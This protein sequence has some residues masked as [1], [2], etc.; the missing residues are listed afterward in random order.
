MADP[1]AI[2]TFARTFG[3]RRIDLLISNAALQIKANPEY[4][5]LLVSQDDV[6]RELCRQRAENPALVRRRL[7][8][9]C[10]MAPVPSAAQ[11]IGGPSDR[12]AGAQ[13]SR[14]CPGKPA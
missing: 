3:G 11:V 2:A 8:D 4:R 14:T 12:L 10:G 5:Y 1:G 7:R 13:R 6:G 9:T